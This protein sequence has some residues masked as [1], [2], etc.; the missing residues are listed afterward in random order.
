MKARFA[1]LIV[2]AGATLGPQGR[3]RLAEVVEAFVASWSAAVAVT[4][5]EMA[6][7]R[8]IDAERFGAA[9]PAQ[10]EAVFRRRG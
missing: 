1:S 7:Q 10:V 6:R 9:D 3:E 2:A 8:A 4:P 5:G